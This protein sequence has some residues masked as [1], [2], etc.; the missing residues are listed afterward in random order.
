MSCH[1]PVSSHIYALGT[2]VLDHIPC[3]VCCIDHWWFRW[4]GSALIQLH[5]S[6]LSRG[7]LGSNM[8]KLNQYILSILKWM[9]PW[10]EHVQAYWQL[11]LWLQQDIIRTEGRGKSNTNYIRPLFL[12]CASSHLHFLSSVADVAVQ[13]FWKPGCLSWC[14]W[15]SSSQ[16]PWPSTCGD[17]GGRL[18]TQWNPCRSDV[19]L[20][21]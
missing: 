6:L 13:A 19:G 14:W 17:L 2:L 7:K 20:T 10:L 5:V 11:V 21:F 16:W 3:L 8:P 4:H 15:A 1:L 9:L 12:L 18:R